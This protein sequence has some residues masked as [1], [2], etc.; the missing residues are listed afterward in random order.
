MA[1]PFSARPT[2]YRVVGE[3]TSWWANCAWDALAIPTMLGVDATIEAAC[4]DC[5]RAFDLRVA[6]GDL[7]GD[8]GVVQFVVA[9]SRFWDDVEFT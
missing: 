9:P 6:S 4:P 5:G 7:V 2:S 3:A 8:D 1:H